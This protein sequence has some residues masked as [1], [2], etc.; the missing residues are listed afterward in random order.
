VTLIADTGALYAAFDR[1]DAHH[2]QV[3]AYLGGLDEKPVV[4][5]LVLAEL[6]HLATVRLGEEARAVI[7]AELADTTYV[8]TFTH[9]MFVT[10]ADVAAQHGS[11]PLGLTDASV[12]VIAHEYGIRDIL[13]TDQRHFRAVRPLLGGRDASFRLL[14]FDA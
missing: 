6:D 7:M 10:V 3:T 9:A 12:M 1:S 4:S 8:A 14:P 11:F 2:Q 5:P 13:T